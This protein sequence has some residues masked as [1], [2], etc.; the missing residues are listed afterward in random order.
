MATV[1]VAAHTASIAIR[2][3]TRPSDAN[4]TTWGVRLSSLSA[5]IFQNF[6]SQLK[7]LRNIGF[8]DGLQLNLQC[9]SAI[10]SPPTPS[11]RLQ[12]ALVDRPVLLRSRHRLHPVRTAHLYAAARGFHA[13]GGI[14]LGSKRSRPQGP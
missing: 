7:C 12:Y 1:A 10:H 9:S 8:R 14:G 13:G 5:Q 11:C 3:T 4:G 6:P 2:S